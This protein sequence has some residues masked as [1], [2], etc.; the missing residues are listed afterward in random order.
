MYST[1][2]CLPLETPVLPK[3][4]SLPMFYF[5]T[6]PLLL[7]FNMSIN[8]SLVEETFR[9]TTQPL[10]SLDKWSFDRKKN[11]TDDYNMNKTNSPIFESFPKQPFKRLAPADPTQFYNQWYIYEKK[12][13]IAIIIGL[14]C[15]HLWY[16]LTHLPFLPSFKDQDNDLTFPQLLLNPR[17]LGQ[18]RTT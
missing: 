17:M 1:E 4:L 3:P 15:L 7:T 2:Q 16:C 10:S 8:C 13:T 6:H 5:D 12:E 9:T 11:Q 14:D 18:L